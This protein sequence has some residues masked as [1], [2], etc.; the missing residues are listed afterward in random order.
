MPAMLVGDTVWNG[1]D[2]AGLGGGSAK[3]TAGRWLRNLWTFHKVL[4]LKD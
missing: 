1:H 3:T 2:L 4:R